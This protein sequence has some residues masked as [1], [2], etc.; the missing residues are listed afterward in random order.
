MFSLLT[1]I[2]SALGSLWLPR[3]RQWCDVGG[4]TR[5][6]SLPLP[7]TTDARNGS[8]HPARFWASSGAGALTRAS[9][10]TPPYSGYGL[11]V[12]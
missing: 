10:T 12:G 7:V 2:V 1:A 9:T 11:G 5:G 8:P 4:M 6:A 3:T